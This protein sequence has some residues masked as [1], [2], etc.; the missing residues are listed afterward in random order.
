MDHRAGR[1]KKASKLFMLVVFF[2]VI[3]SEVLLYTGAWTRVADSMQK[4]E[5]I[6]SIRGRCEQYKGQ[7][8]ELQTCFKAVFEEITDRFGIDIALAE[9]NKMRDTNIEFAA[10]CHVYAHK[11][12]E[13]A[14]ARYKGN[15]K[16][17]I[18]EN[19]NLCNFGFFHGFMQEFASHNENLDTARQFC[20]RVLE[21]T[22][23]KH[24]IINAGIYGSNCD[25][26]M[27]HGLAYKNAIAHWGN[28]Q[29]IAETSVADCNTLSR[30][31]LRECIIGAYGG[32]AAMYFELH[33][34]TLVMDK[35]D[36]FR[37]C[38]TRPKEERVACYDGLVPPLHFTFDLDFDKAAEFILDI[39][40]HDA[41]LV[42]MRH[43]G[44]MPSHTLVPTTSDYSGIVAQCRKYPQDFHLTCLGGFAGSLLH[45]GSHSDAE[46]RTLTFCASDLTEDERRV[47]YLGAIE[48][49][50][51]SYSREDLLS[52]C[53]RIDT[54]YQSVCI[55]YQKESL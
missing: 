53:G 4:K 11:I 13:K 10:D 20:I 24:N 26:G 8:Y 33:G 9:L 27:G 5:G 18:S 47:C 44:T 1:F 19:T 34:Y 16:F 23:A 54:M 14:Y 29:A 35:E 43:L 31:D 3:F 6:E 7:R 48:T 2:I 42:A 52:F 30:V 39:P 46:N 15:P 21:E 25:H 49:L 36:P 12:G 22:K 37:L 38:H 40:D 17:S 55:P 41:A 50:Q 32:I 51:Y 28:E 45:I